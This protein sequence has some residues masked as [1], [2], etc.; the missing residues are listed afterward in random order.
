MI[1]VKPDKPRREDLALQN[2]KFLSWKRLMGGSKSAE[3]IKDL[4][5]K[6]ERE[7]AT[8]REIYDETGKHTAQEAETGLMRNSANQWIFELGDRNAKIK[9]EWYNDLFPRLDPE[10]GGVV[11]DQLQNVYDHPELYKRM[12]ELQSMPTQLVMPKR[13]DTNVEK[14]ENASGLYIPR[15]EPNKHG[16]YAQGHQQFDPNAKDPNSLLGVL[17]HEV[18]HGI[19]DVDLLPFGSSKGSWL[20]REWGN[21]MSPYLNQRMM[22]LISSRS[23]RKKGTSQEDWLMSNPEWLETATNI[24]AARNYTPYEKYRRGTA[25]E[26]MAEMSAD[27]MSWPMQGRRDNP[28]FEA[29]KY[30]PMP[31]QMNTWSQGEPTAPPREVFARWLMEQRLKGGK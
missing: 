29:N 17:N 26:Q 10:G 12:P 13:V 24:D 14:A 30:E 23:K 3:D 16:I 28:A 15:Q 31:F 6:L 5:H 7:G 25:G 18:N 22:E 27:R 9:P 11:T 2:A 4:A 20:D 8:Q 21:T 1:A 19:Q